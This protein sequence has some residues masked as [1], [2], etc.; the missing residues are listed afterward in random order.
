VAELTIEIP[1]R[2]FFKPSEVCEIVRIQPYVLRSWE[3]EFPRLG[4]ARTPGA[5]RTYRRSDVELAL[6]I[7]QLVFS[8]GLTLAGARRR[9]DS[10]E[11]PGAPPAPMAAP[12]Q[13]ETRA[14][15][16]AIRQELRDLADM[17][18]SAPG[19]GPAARAEDQRGVP[20]VAVQTA[21][22]WPAA[23]PGP[24]VPTSA[25]KPKGGSRSR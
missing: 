11:E 20:E 25:A 2:E 1:D 18:S 17:L 5:S 7:K 6:R 10:A 16:A 14:R 3:Q 23:K 8:E 15:V 12:V 22:S 13:N 21:G 9:L 4:V 24:A 19:R